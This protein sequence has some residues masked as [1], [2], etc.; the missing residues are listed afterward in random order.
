MQMDWKD[1]LGALQGLPEGA[2][3]PLDNVP[4]PES[5]RQ[6]GKLNVVVEKK[7]RG[8]KIAT[9]VEGFTIPDEE[10]A[11]IAAKLKKRLGSGGSARGGEILIQGSRRDDVIAALKSMGLKC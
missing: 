10:V 6:K 1:A 4:A 8:G 11:E 9:I 3:E 5:P 7:G 2:P